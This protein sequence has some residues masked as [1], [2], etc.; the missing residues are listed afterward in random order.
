AAAATQQIEALAEYQRARAD[1]MTSTGRSPSTARPRPRSA[2]EPAPMEGVSLGAASRPL[3]AA[4][5][6]PG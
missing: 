1:F 4:G 5:E 2:A 3:R 6:R